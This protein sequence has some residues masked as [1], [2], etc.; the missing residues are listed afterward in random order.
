[1][2]TYGNSYYKI[3]AQELINT[4]LNLL[5]FIGA[6]LHQEKVLLI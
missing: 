4:S 3:K 5:D 1:M 6:Y 2:G